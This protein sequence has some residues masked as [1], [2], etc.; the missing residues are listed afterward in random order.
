MT[1]PEL[2]VFDWDGTL[3]DSA[4][5]IVSAMVHASKAL[6]IPTP[7]TRVMRR[8][9]GLGLVEAFAQIFPDRSEDERQALMARYREHYQRLPERVFGQPFPAVDTTLAL[10]EERGHTLAVATGKSRAG[11]DRSLAAVPWGRVF[12]E[13]RCADE[14]ASKP[15]P[16]ML[17]EL[18]LV[19]CVEPDAM[20]MVGD[21]TYDM[22]MARRFGCA[23]VGVAWGVH[24]RE[25]LLEAGAQQVFA[26][27]ADLPHWLL[28][29]R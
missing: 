29:P 10:L 21:T 19:L 14:T 4:G 6:A 2:I 5:D 3:V 18:S 22:E 27:V 8:A 9:I 25:E 1:R 16:R 17:E 28:Q 24:E 13:S 26:S 7:D 11:L 23:A 15:D 12:R 20:L